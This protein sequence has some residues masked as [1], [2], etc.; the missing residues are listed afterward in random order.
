[1]NKR[2]LTL[3]FAFLALI[4]IFVNDISRFNDGKLHLV[5]CNVGQGDAIFIKTPKGDDILIDGGPD[6]L[7]LN[8]L[9]NHMPFWDKTI[10][11]MVLTHPHADHLTGLISVLKRYQVIHYFTENVKN[12]T[13]IYKR[14]QDILAEKKVTAKY[15]FSGDRIDFSDKT[16]LLTIWPDKIWFDNQKLQDNQDL[17]KDNISLDVNGFSVIQK[18]S[19]GNFTALLTGDAGVLIEDRIAN[20]V[21]EIDLLKVPHHGSKTGMSDYFLSQTNPSLAVISVAAKNRYSHPAKIILDLLQKHNIKTL[22]TDI[23]GEVELISDGKTFNI[24]SN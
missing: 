13:L 7:V 23:N 19:Y 24:Y 15:T 9:S 10:E 12:D 22:R 16:S 18:L 2:I 17:V 20:Q 3:T 5:I 21:G 11:V 14:L 8:C 6:E 1:M 4:G